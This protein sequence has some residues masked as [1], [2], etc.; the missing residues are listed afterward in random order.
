MGDRKFVW[1]RDP[2]L[3]AHDR[4]VLEEGKALGEARGLAKAVLMVL[5]ASSVAVAAEERERIL[6]TTDEVILASWLR[7]AA[8]VGRAE[9]LFAD[10]A[11]VDNDPSIR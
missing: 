9:E 1:P 4:K 8:Q 10:A 6:A 5:E 2:W 7:R 11:W 3:D